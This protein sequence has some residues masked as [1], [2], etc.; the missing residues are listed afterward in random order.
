MELIQNPVYII[1][2]NITSSNMEMIINY[3]VIVGMQNQSV[4]QNMNSRIFH[5]ANSLINEQ[6][7]RL[8][9]QGYEDITRLFM[10]GWY[11]IKNNQRG[12]LS[13]SL[14]NYTFP[15]PAANGF[16]VIKSLTFNIQDGTIYQLG[17]LFKPN[18]NY[19][20]VLSD[21]IEE[22]I[23]KR[24]IPLISEYKGIQPDQ[25]YYIAD[26]ILVIYFQ[27]LEL[28]PHYFGFLQFPI[29]VY[30]I[31]DIIKENGP[32]GKMAENT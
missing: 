15:F 2:Q 31:K 26:K 24:D 5:L 29:S 12:I 27:L 9:N 16:T 32:L 18:S 17:D 14:G 1:T 10:Q 23:K 11:E 25:D 20:K 3:P 28:T 7:R 19:V 4:Q 6:I 30:E 13:L 8:V 22:Q 21:I